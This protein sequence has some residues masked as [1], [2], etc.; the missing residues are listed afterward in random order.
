MPVSPVRLD[1]LP[2]GSV[3]II[4]RIERQAPE[5]LRYL[6]ALGLLAGTRVE[7]EEVAPFGGPCLVRVGTARYALGRDVAAHIL[8]RSV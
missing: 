1:R 5:L 2:P 4:E 3:A 8:V 7:V 6:A